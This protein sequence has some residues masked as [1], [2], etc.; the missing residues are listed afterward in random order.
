MKLNYMEEIA[1]LF[2]HERI[3]QLCQA[4]DQNP[5]SILRENLLHYMSMAVDL[6]HPVFNKGQKAAYLKVRQD[7]NRLKLVN[8]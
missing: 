5:A 3:H 2:Q 8:S 6:S 7:L 4:I 1:P